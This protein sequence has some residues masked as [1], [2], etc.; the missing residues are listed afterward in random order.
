MIVV[1]WLQFHRLSLCMEHLD[2]TSA[3]FH[4]HTILCLRAR[5]KFQSVM[6]QL[7]H[8][9]NIFCHLTNYSGPPNKS[10]ITI[11]LIQFKY[12]EISGIHAMC[13]KSSTGFNIMKEIRRIRPRVILQIT[14]MGARFKERSLALIY[15]PYHL[16]DLDVQSF[17]NKQ[18]FLEIFVHVQRQMI[19]SGVFYLRMNK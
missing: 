13:N 9:K 15:Q 17:Y 8:V 18:Q 1:K 7:C 19:K 10:C 6:L 3:F 12:L 14:F 16:S 11:V 5:P 4:M 2:F